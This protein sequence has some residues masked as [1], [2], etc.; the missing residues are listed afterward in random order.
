MTVDRRAILAAKPFSLDDDAISWVEQQLDSMSEHDKIG[1]LFIL[2]LLGDD[3]TGAARMAAFKPAGVKRFFGPDI[4]SET[5]LIEQLRS[6][7][8]VPLLIPSD[9]EGSR[10]SLPFGTEVPNPLAMAAI[11]DEDAQRA[12]CD[13]MARDAVSMGVNLSFTPVLDICADSRSAI[14]PTRGFGSDIERIRRLAR[15][16]VE[17]LQSHGIAATAKHWPGEGY[18]ARDQHLVTTINPLAMDE[19]HASFG[20]LY[21]DMIDAGVMAVMSAHIALPAYVAAHDAD[22]GVELYRPAC[23]SELLNMSLLRGD[24]GFNGVIISDASGMAGLSSWDHED[25]A[26]AELVANGCDLIL[27]SDDPELDRSR[28]KDAL[29]DGRL[30]RD[31][32]DEAVT[33]TLGLK[34]AL[35]LHREQQPLDTSGLASAE[36]EATARSIMSRVPTLVKD[37]KNLLPLSVAEH[38]KLYVFTTGVVSPITGVE[39]LAMLDLLRDEGF[40]VTVH[41]PGFSLKPWEGHDSVLYLMGEESLLTRQNIFLNWAQLA[42]NFMQAMMRPWNDVPTALVSFGHPFYLADAPRMPC[43]VNAYTTIDSM[44]QAVVECLL[45]R[46]PFLGTSPVDPAGGAPDAAY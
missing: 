1:Q 17:V 27:F 2:M 34:A 46:A 15:T 36:D 41:E 45:G 11:D 24:L 35:G 4:E 10:M 28:I 5:A 21:A 19:W 42:G 23:V 13:I 32:L 43:V 9:T 3:P 38:K 33:R 39:P 31:R 29:A 6:D 37:T 44:Q 20:K 26:K 12:I 25:V 8:S 14:V 7:A 22:A 18:D 16:Q 40:V 30:G